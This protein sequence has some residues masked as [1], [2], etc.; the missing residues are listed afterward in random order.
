MFSQTRDSMLVTLFSVVK[1]CFR[2]TKNI[3]S[4]F[5]GRK[6]FNLKTVV[7][8]IFVRQKNFSKITKSC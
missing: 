8:M 6:A 7:E 5:V 2:Q 1:T 3:F 4:D